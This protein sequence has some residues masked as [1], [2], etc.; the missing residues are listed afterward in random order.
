MFLMVV[1]SFSFMIERSTFVAMMTSS[2]FFLT[3]MS[4]SFLSMMTSSFFLAMMFFIMFPF[5]FSFKATR[6]FFILRIFPSMRMFLAYFFN[7]IL[8]LLSLEFTFTSLLM[9]SSMFVV[10]RISSGHIRFCRISI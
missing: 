8:I 2:S 1:M 4:S 3:M 7:I 9:M 6:T 10:S 5:L